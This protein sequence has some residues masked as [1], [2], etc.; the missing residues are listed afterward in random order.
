[1]TIFSPSRPSRDTTASSVAKLGDA[2]ARWLDWLSKKLFDVDALDLELGRDDL[3]DA[4]D[5]DADAP[6]DPR[7][8]TLRWATPGSTRSEAGS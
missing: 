6:T 5:E 2:G 1:M 7:R 4:P 3:P 8:N